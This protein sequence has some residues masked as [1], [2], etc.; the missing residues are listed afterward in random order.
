MIADLIAAEIEVS[1]RCTLPQKSSKALCPGIT[2][3][4]AAEIEVT[5]R[6]ALTQHSC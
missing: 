5:E 1:Q 6:C 2:D 4:I 3:L